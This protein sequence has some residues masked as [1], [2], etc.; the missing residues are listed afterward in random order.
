MLLENQSTY[1]FVVVIHK[2]LCFATD[3]NNAISTSRFATVALLDE[4]PLIICESCLKAASP[5]V[6]DAIS[7]KSPNIRRSTYCVSSNTSVIFLSKHMAS[8]LPIHLFLCFC[9]S[10]GII[11]SQRL[12]RSH[13]SLYECLPNF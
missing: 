3:F 8:N 11:L 6:A 4:I 10:R 12:P 5:A 2:C 7:D 13:A 1:I 9:T